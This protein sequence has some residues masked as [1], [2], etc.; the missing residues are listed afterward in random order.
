MWVARA[1]RTG[2][3]L[4]G[5]TASLGCVE[6]S[7]R[8]SGEPMNYGPMPAEELPEASPGAI[9]RGN[10]TSGSFLFFDQK[11]RGLGDL[12]T[13]LV[14]EQSEAQ[15]EAKTE[16]DRESTL[17]TNL[18]SDVGLQQLIAR[19]FRNFFRIFGFDGAG[20]T[21]A[22]GTQLNVI[23]SNNES[24]FSGD[25]LTSRKG[26]FSGIVTCRVIDVLPG[27]L[28]H[29]RGRRSLVIN[30][31]AQLI[32]LEGLVRREDIGINNTVSSM[33]L[34]E[35]R[36]TYDGLGVIDDRQRPGWLVRAFDWLYPF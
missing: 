29:V 19:P 7:L 12:V 36:L 25:G 30:H 34:A 23:E 27:G 21:V 10:A 16:T 31:E 26:T 33:S 8:Q 6:A 20:R 14:M 11:A 35:M 17:G 4:A 18:T 15:G 28:F 24:E 22:E 13:V 1:A 5:L 2:L 3:L 9:W 32:T